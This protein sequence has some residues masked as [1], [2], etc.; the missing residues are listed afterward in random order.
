MYVRILLT[1]LMIMTVLSPTLSFAQG[2]CCLKNMIDKQ[3]PDID[4]VPPCHDPG[5]DKSSNTSQPCLC[6][7][8][9]HILSEQNNPDMS[10]ITISYSLYHP[11][12]NNIFHLYKR[13]TPPFRPPITLS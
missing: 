7:A 4:I 3:H 10:I 8:G 2:C 6:D 9:L 1:L 5:A 13:L 12:E 11:Q